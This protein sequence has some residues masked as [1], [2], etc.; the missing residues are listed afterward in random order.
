MPLE[1]RKS[2]A[3]DCASC[4]ETGPAKS[5][6]PDSRQIKES[7][8]LFMMILVVVKLVYVVAKVRKKTDYHL[9]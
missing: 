3:N 2:L 9:F 1:A 8:I 7:K 6:S 4:L 5:W